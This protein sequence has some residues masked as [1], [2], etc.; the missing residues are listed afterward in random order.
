LGQISV[1]SLRLKELHFIIFSM[2]RLRQTKTR[3]KGKEL[4]LGSRK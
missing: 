1:D 3:R 2:P 4:S